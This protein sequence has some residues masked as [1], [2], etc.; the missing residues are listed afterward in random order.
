MT[1]SG[2]R[3]TYGPD[4]GLRVDLTRR[5][6]GVWSIANFVVQDL[7]QLNLSCLADWDFPY[8][9][10]L[11]LQLPKAGPAGFLPG[12]WMTLPRGLL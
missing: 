7:V 5:P 6:I 10:L 3:L 8:V 12:W 11:D 4:G 9:S 1:L 2:V